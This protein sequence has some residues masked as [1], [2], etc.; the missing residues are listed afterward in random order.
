VV[1]P[2][3]LAGEVRRRAGEALAAYSEASPNV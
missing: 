3:E 2:P 1:T